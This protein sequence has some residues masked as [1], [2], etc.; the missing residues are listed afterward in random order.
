M[1]ALVDEAITSG[2]FIKCNRFEDI[3]PSI[4]RLYQKEVRF[5]DEFLRAQE[6]MTF[7]FDGKA[8]NRAADVIL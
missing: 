4:Y 6:R 8:G 3:L 2:H 1:A 5:N 7:R